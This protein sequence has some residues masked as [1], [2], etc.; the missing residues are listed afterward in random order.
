M[1]PVVA[2][3]AELS[4]NVDVRILA[5]DATKGATVEEIVALILHNVNG[6]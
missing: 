2:R 5:R 3:L 1:V 4:S 6:T